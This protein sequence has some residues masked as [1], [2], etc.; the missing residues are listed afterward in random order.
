MKKIFLVFLLLL[1]VPT[2][3]AEVTEQFLEKSLEVNRKA[4]SNE[5]TVRDQQVEN[6]INS[7][8]DTFTSEIKHK[9][10]L[11]L[12]K[13]SLV[14]IS[15]IVIGGIILKSIYLFINKLLNN[16]ARLKVA[17]QQKKNNDKATKNIS[18][19]KAA[20]EQKKLGLTN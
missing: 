15:S 10:S 3:N 1:L 19:N 20:A 12:F 18:K 9:Y 8:F 13:L 16:A 4:F 2:I 14:L 17:A 11:F 7:K 5:L 6:R